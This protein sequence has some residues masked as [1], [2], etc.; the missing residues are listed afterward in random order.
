[1]TNGTENSP[2]AELLNLY[3]KIMEEND[4]FLY[5]NAEFV[6]NE[7]SGLI[8]DAIDL[9]GSRLVSHEDYTRRSMGFFIH[10]ILLSASS[11]IH[12][13]L[14]IGNLPA[15]FAELRLMLESLVKCYLADLG[16]P[17]QPFFQKKLELLENE[18]KSTSKLMRELGKVLGV[19]N[20]FNALWS[21]LSNDWVHTKGLV[22]RVVNQFVE[23]SAPPAWALVIPMA[24]QPSDL[25]AIEELGKRISQFRMLFK[26]AIEKYQQL[27]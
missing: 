15:C 14:L 11:A 27:E 26:T 20:K 9:I 25:E 22:A 5:E 17:D 12:T 18:G 21:K 16:Y 4:K 3:S 10:H 7:V 1:M 23:K 2:A 24:Y 19:G 13:N 8:N 6:Y